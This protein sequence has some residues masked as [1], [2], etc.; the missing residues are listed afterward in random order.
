MLA[1]SIQPSW[2]CT[3]T[4]EWT[5]AQQN[6]PNNDEIAIENLAL[7]LSNEIFAK[8][9]TFQG[10]LGLPKPTTDPPRSENFVESIHQ[11]KSLT[12][13]QMQVV[14]TPM[15]VVAAADTGEHKKC[16]SVFNILHAHLTILWHQQLYSWNHIN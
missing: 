5:Q 12:N 3:A 1:Y 11:N 9:G 13:E 4:L 14:N 6:L 15:Q 8:D 16:G 7:Y 2:E 10:A